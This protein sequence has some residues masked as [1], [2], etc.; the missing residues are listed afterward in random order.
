MN[1]GEG[2]R[3]EEEIGD[4]TEDWEGR[5]GRREGD[6]GGKRRRR[7]KEWKRDEDIGKGRRGLGLEGEEGI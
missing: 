5:G 3:R 7:G 6:W 4:R 1:I 2:R